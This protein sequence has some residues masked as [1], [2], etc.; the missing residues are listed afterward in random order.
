MFSVLFWIGS[1]TCGGP[2]GHQ[3]GL[4]QRIHKLL[5]RD[6]DP[7]GYRGLLAW[8]GSDRVDVANGVCVK[9]HG[10]FAFLLR[11]K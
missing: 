7:E 5:R 8:H 3:R 10:L 9:I 1:L 11:S 6:A 2:N 4:V